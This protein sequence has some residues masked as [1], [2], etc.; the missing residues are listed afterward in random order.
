MVAAALII[1]HVIVHALPH[2]VV[3]VARPKKMKH[4]CISSSGTIED[5]QFFIS[6]W[7]D[8]V[9]TIKLLGTNRVIQILECCNHRL[10]RDLIQ[11]AG[12]TL[13][14]K[15][16]NK[17]LAAMKILAVREENV[18]VA[19]VTL[20]NMKQ[21]RGEPICSFGS[22]LQGRQVYVSSHNKVPISMLMWIILKP[23]YEMCYVE[24]WEIQLVFL[25]DK[26]QD[27]TL[28]QILRFVEA[29]EARKR[30]A[31]QL[32]LPRAPDAVIGSSY[33]RQKRD[34]AE[35]PSPRD[36]DPCRYCE[37]GAMA[38]MPLLDD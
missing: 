24:V 28:E 15:T 23:Y 6:R 37:R 32:F 1:A 27:M 16:E 38:E 21:D 31:I 14:R 7:N 34:A 36:Q 5:W 12:G 3:P 19:R 26:N 30:S 33:K 17:V 20:H 11:N 35:G 4:L 22:R 13:T 9:R 29:K 10:W 18:M 25:G 8:Y 2:S